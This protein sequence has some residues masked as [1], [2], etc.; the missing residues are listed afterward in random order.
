M[1][2]MNSQSNGPSG[3]PSSR[4]ER[5]CTL[6]TTASAITGS[7]GCART[8]VAPKTRRTLSAI[9]VGVVMFV[10]AITAAT[11]ASAAGALTTGTGCP[12]GYAC[13]YPQNAGWNG[14]KPSAR[15]YRYGSYN[16]VNQYGTHRFFNNQTGGAGAYLCTGYNG[17]GTCYRQAPS[18][19]GTPTSPRS[20]RSS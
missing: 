4:E 17:G 2:R 13:L 20:T 18:T 12:S 15:Y 3:T 9:A 1:P 11:P 6:S 5:D 8:T 16:L 10:S 7:V 14:G 19:S